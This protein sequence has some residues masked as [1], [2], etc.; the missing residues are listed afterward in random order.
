M[1]RVWAVMDRYSDRQLQELKRQL[2]GERKLTEDEKKPYIKKIQDRIYEGRVREL[3]EKADA[4]EG[5]NYTLTKRVL[6]EV[7]LRIFRK[8]R[9]IRCGRS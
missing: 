5:K 7:K 9:S 4:C 6:E 1:R 2:E 8:N 3:Q